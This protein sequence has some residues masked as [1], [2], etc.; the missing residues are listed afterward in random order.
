MKIG[1]RKVLLCSCERTMSID[2][3]KIAAALGLDD[4]GT[5]HENLCRMEVGTFGEALEAGE[6][7]LVACTQEAPLFLELAEDAQSDTPLSFTNIREYAG[8]HGGKTDVSAKMAALLAEAALDIEPAESFTLKSD[9]VCLVYGSGQAALDV[10]RKLGRRLSVTL[11]M[12]DGGELMPPG[13]VDV[14]IYCGTIASA[15]GGFG[16]FE[17]SVDGYAPAVPSSKDALTFTMA[18]D[19]AAAQCDLI[20]DMSGGTA[21]FA[22]YERREGYFRVDPNHPAAVAEAMFEISDLV[23]EFEKPIY[24][25]YRGDICAHSR[26]RKT[27]CT[28]CLDVCPASAIMPDGDIVHIDAVLCGGCGACASVCPSGAASYSMPRREDLIKRAQTLLSTYRKGGGKAPGLIVHDER[29]GAE[30]IGAMARYGR[31]LPANVIPFPVQEVTS[32]GHDVLVAAVASGAE[33]V[34]LLC[35]PRKRDELAGLEAQ[36]A[37]VAAL[38]DGLGYE[39][40]GR[41]ELVVEADPDALEAMLYDGAAMPALAAHT[42]TAAGD[43]RTIAR[44]ALS[45][46]NDAAQAPKD[47]IIL[48]EGAPYGRVVVDTAGCTLCLACVSACPANALQDNPEMPQLRFVEAACVQCGLCRNTCPESVITLEPRFNFTSEALSPIVL[49][50][51][52][53]FECISCGKPFGTRG[54]VERITERLAGKHWMFETEGAAKLIQMCDDC[55]IVHHSKSQDNPFSGGQRPRIRTTNDY[56]QAEERLRN[57]GRKGELT[58]EDF[59]FEEE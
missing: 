25:R 1:D 21:L 46:L 51:E 53:P 55:R 19:G 2:A 50:E 16:G 42:F 28:R 40:G 5:V 52:D 59:L 54:A 10:A 30:L 36:V 24:V 12:P 7:L 41:V 58:A 39:G 44:M 31:G 23:G 38:L 11:L 27:G 49:H 13:T 15:S 9:G 18:R 35:D 47:A 14:P 26:N 4:A 8:W 3:A 17:V 6:P 56:L 22:S 43:K 45:L 57:S 32:L 48:P 37:L 20:F 33:R 29:H 34:V